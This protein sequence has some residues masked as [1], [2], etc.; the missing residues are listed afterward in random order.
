MRVKVKSTTRRPLA[1]AP[2][3]RSP[4]V[5][6]TDLSGTASGHLYAM[7]GR[8]TLVASDAD[9]ARWLGLRGPEW[10]PR[11]NLCP[12][13]DLLVVRRGEAGE[14]E[15][16]PLRWGLIAWWAT[17]PRIAFQCINARAETVATKPAFR[18]AFRER[19]CLIIV[20][21][22]YE[23]A[24][25]TGRRKQPHA[26]RMPDGAPFAFAGLWESWRPSEGADP[27]ETCTIVTTVTCQ[28]TARLHHRM[29]VVLS[30]DRY[31]AWL[32]PY[33]SRRE[34]EAMLTPYEGALDVFPVSSLVN[35]GKVDDERCLDRIAVTA[36][37]P[38]RTAPPVIGM[39]GSGQGELPL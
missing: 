4:V 10:T 36:E 27:I 14:L 3:R 31:A 2:Y 33:M 6:L 15:L 9:I 1:R 26:I 25:E 20:D 29:P 35:A 37:D 22:W 19:R 11:F 12:G 39:D 8:T 7:C 13:Q 38:S 17:D 32:D 34:L 5:G 21:G 18:D 23:W 30:E 28:A 24:T 16:R